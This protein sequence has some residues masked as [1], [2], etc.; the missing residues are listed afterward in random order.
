MLKTWR[1]KRKA[2]R[3]YMDGTGESMRGEFDESI[4]TL[5]K[6]IELDPTLLDAYFV[7]GISFLEINRN[8]QALLDFN[9]VIQNDPD[10]STNYYHRSLTYVA[11]GMRD[12]AL[13]DVTKA[14]A[15]DPKN[16]DYYKYRCILYDGMEDYK[17]AIADATMAI[18]FGD[19]T[20]GHNNRAI[21]YE[22]KGEFQA[23]I[24]DW[25]KFLELDSN[26]IAAYCLRGI[27][28]EK[29]GNIEEAIADLKKGLKKKDEIDDKL[30]IQ[31]EELLQR[32]EKRF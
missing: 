12:K 31:S 30:R 7:R 3:Y 17:L 32:L 19:A 24:D 5:L 8:N 20:G 27:L 23:A 18:K 2:R 25:T 21:V 6:A 13:L 10:T 11:L 16:P 14:I 9:F 22:H 29:V 26:D 15:L 4:K 28:F 1:T